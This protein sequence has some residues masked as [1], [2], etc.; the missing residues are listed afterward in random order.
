M[1]FING[2]SRRQIIMMP[3]C[4][5]GYI[6]DS[7]SARAIEGRRENR[8][9]GGRARGRHRYDGR[10]RLGELRRYRGETR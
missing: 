6:R 8:P 2:E 3:D 7:N 1:V 9:C 4:I 10:Q 5:D